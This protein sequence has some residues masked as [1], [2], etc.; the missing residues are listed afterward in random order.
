MGSINRRRGAA[1]SLVVVI[2]ALVVAAAAIGGII[3][4]LTIRMPSQQQMAE[5][6]KAM[7]STSGLGKPVKNSL[8]PKFTDGNGDGIADAPGDAS[9]LLDPPTLAF[10]FIATEDSQQF[11]D[12]FKDL[13]AAIEKATGKK[14]EYVP[15]TSTDDEL[16]AMADGKLHIVGLS[17]G[18]V[19]IAVDACGLVPVCSLGDSKGKAMSQME[20]IVPADSSIQSVQDLKGKELTLTDPGSNSGYKA[21]LVLLKNDFGMLPG[22]DYGIV[23]SG[24]QDKSVTGIASKQY[25]A[26]AVSSDVLARDVASGVIKQ[27]DFRSIYKSGSFPT[28]GFGYVYNLKPELAEKIRNAIL[29]FNW[30]GTGLE[31]EFSATG[32]NRFTPVNYKDDWALVRKIDDEIGYVHQVK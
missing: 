2:L 16:K 10:S 9:Q 19:P 27:G 32:Q 8:D 14:V 17:T 4:M 31:K 28:A 1:G 26:A 24:E 5:V 25:K 30:S 18:S 3:Y 11:K 20:I 13:L 23:Y 22:R 29:Q 21:P 15:F 7:L 12:A 6:E